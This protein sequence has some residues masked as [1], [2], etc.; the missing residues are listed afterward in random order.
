MS[1][2]P[3]PRTLEPGAS[4]ELRGRR[5]G[6]RVVVIG[7]GWAG[8]AAAF[9]ARESHAEVIVVDGGVGASGLGSGALDDVPWDERERAARTLGAS[10][11][12]RPDP[13]SGGIATD[14]AWIAGYFGPGRYLVGDV[15]VAL[16]IV[17]TTA[18]RLRT[19]SAIDAA[20]LDLARLPEG[21][22]VLVPRVDRAAWDADSIVRQLAAE[23]HA[24]ARGLAF[25]AVEADVLRYDDERRIPDAD[26]AM[27]HDEPARLEWLEAQLR[28][29]VARAGAGVA[30]LLLG[31]WLG[32]ASP[33]AA[34]LSAALEIAV[35]EACIP[36]AATAGLRFEGAFTA[37]AR[38]SAVR[39]LRDRVTRIEPRDGRSR[40]HL[41]SG[42]VLDADA[43]VLAIGGLVGGGI[44]FDPP[45]HGAGA[46]GA[47][48]IR[49][50]FR[51]SVECGV[52]V[53][54]RGDVGVG[55]SAFGPA[56][57]E[58]AWPMAGAAGSLELVGLGAGDLRDRPLHAAGDVLAGRARTVGEAVASGRRAGVAAATVA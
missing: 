27:R 21:S 55:S 53:E 12:A 28:D 43:V 50:P 54:A 17:A 2:Q 38:R 10:L 44:V 22:R 18:G 35:G 29:A 5:P 3:P 4:A 58:A 23:P 40:V 47:E 8:A 52:R 15:G 25:T 46:E 24:Q 19:A 1:A 32:I 14:L 48:A 45:E 36:T 9:A 42:E 20:L 57:D 37:A 13:L 34:T 33:R 7:A 11:I 31:P 30:A 26:L 49:S 51:I 16:P 6:H 56:F 41:K 39:V